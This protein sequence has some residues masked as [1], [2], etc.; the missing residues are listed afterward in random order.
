MLGVG[1]H[2]II[3][4][5]SGMG[6]KVLEL[7]DRRAVSSL[8]L[9]RRTRNHVGSIYFG[10]QMTQA[11]IT[12]GLLL[13]RHFPPGPWGMLVKR[14]E[15]DFHAKA[16]G[17]LRAVCEPPAEVLAALDEART[18]ESGKAEGWVPVELT[19]E[20]GELVA[21]ARFLAAVKRFR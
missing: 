21:A 3:P 19:N 18:N 7:S 20:S 11:E 10:A 2:Q 14:V 4:L 17:T 13:F 6:M 15:A 8:P 16:K 5:T 1:I 9:K 12:M